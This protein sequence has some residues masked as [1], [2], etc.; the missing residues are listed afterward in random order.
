MIGKYSI[1]LDVYRAFLTK[2]MQVIPV[3][4]GDK[5]CTMYG[6]QCGTGI[7]NYFFANGKVY[8]CG[9]CINL[10][11]L[12]PSSMSFFELEKIVLKF[13]RNCCYKELLS[14]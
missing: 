7:N 13:D 1:G 3:R 12:G 6:G 2:A 5:D 10:P 11:P 9:N 4:Q 8:Y 14:L